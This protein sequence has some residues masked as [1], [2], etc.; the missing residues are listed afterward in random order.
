VRYDDLMYVWHQKV[1]GG[2]GPSV[3]AGSN[4]IDSCP[5]ITAGRTSPVWGFEAVTL[6]LLPVA[7][8]RPMPAFPSGNFGEI[9]EGT[10]T[11]HEG[12]WKCLRGS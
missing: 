12:A 6:P 8:E 5:L 4:N 11:R 3:S 10:M 7:S 1:R 9:R 2:G